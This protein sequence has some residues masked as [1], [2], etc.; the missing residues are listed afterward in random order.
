MLSTSK[1]AFSLYQSFAGMFAN[2]YFLDGKRALN[3]EGQYV[4][5][6][7]NNPT[8]KY[9]MANDPILVINYEALAQDKEDPPTKFRKIDAR[10]LDP[11][12]LEHARLG[13]P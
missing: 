1:E 10:Q 2:P 8:Q 3:N 5:G 6:P 4:G 11:T 12:E 13:I 9:T 7:P